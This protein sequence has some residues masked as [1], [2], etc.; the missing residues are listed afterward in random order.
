MDDCAHRAGRERAGRGMKAK[1]VYAVTVGEYG[2]YRIETIFSTQPK[3]EAY[4][5]TRRKL[6][7]WYE[8]RI[9]T[10]TL[11]ARGDDAA[12]IERGAQWWTVWMTKDGNSHIS[13]FFDGDKKR[14]L[15]AAVGERGE[16]V[17]RLVV[18]DWFASK[19][20]AIKTTNELRLQLI[21]AEQWPDPP[22]QI[23]KIRDIK[24]GVTDDRQTTATQ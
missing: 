17:V 16:M 11:D 10:Y 13:S 19:D 21:A 20:H 9:E 23:G 14:M 8:G 15:F 1:Q 5:A 24:L 6:D 4:I 12:R 3:A 18:A 2:D 7:K 22:R